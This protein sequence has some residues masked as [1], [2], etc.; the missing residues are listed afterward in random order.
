MVV[1]AVLDNFFFV[2]FNSE[3]IIDLKLFDYATSFLPIYNFTILQTKNT[4]PLLDNLLWF[5]YD[6]IGNIKIC[7]KKKEIIF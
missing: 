2:I 4:W 1:L 7:E 6:I 3:I 5:K